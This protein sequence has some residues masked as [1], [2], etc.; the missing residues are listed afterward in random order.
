MH[1]R[2][3]TVNTHIS[4]RRRTGAL[5]T[6]WA[7]AAGALLLPAAPAAADEGAAPA[8]REYRVLQDIHTDAVST[9]LD[10]G[11]FT[12]ASK[13]DVP[14]GNGTRFSPDDIWFHVDQ[15]SAT[16]IPA[17]F[18]FIA[19][20][21]SSIWIA[22][23]SNPGTGQLWPGFSTESIPS[24]GV[25]GNQ[26]RFT[27]TG[28]EG[29][30][31]LEL[32]TT[33]GFG[34]T[35]RLWSSDEEFKSF[36]V[37]RT[38]MHANWAFT[39]PGTYRITVEGAVTI[40][41]T[42]ASDTAT[43]TFVVGDLP[44]TRA[45]TTTVSASSTDLVLGEPVTIT[46]AVQPRDAEGY[47]EFR[48]GETLLGHEPVVDGGASLTVPAPVV[49]THQ[50]TAS[51]VPAVSNLATG[52]TS[53]A[54]SVVVTEEPGGTE[55]GIAGVGGSYAP[56]D[57]LSARV[58]GAT[59][60]EDQNFQWRIRPIGTTGGGS[61]VG[62]TGTEA[63]LGRLQLP[64]DASHD[65][66]ELSVRLRT[67]TT[68]VQQTPWVPLQVVNS[69]E[70]VTA[71]LV[72]E[73]PVYLPDAIVVHVGGRAL[74][75]G[76]SLRL[77]DRTSGLWYPVDEE[78]I[79]AVGTSFEVRYPYGMKGEWAV[80][81]IRDGLAVAQSTP[82]AI[83]V[84]NAEV[85]I[86][87]AQGVYRVGATMRA[88][89]SVF[90]EREGL[91]YQWVYFNDS[92]DPFTYEIL[93]EG[94][95]PDVFSVE[96]PLTLEHDG[97]ILGFDVWNGPGGS[98]VGSAQVPINVSD[99]DP[100]EQLFFFQQLGAHYHQGYDINLDLAADPGL[101]EGDTVSWEWRW[102]G[103][104]WAAL[105]GAE[106]LSHDLVAEQAL[107]GVE[108]RATLHFAGG[109]TLTAEPVTIYVDDHGA[110]AHQ[111]ASITGLAEQYTAG[112]EVVLTASVN[113]ASVI[114]RWNWFVQRDGESSP[115]L[116]EDQ[117][118]AELRFAALE[119]LDGA[120]V[121]AQLVL[122]DGSVYVESAPVQ[123][124]IEPAPPVET[125]VTVTGLEESYE[126]G[127]T[128]T[129][130]AEQNPD[131]GEDH[132][133]WFLRHGDGEWTVIPEQ[134]TATLT[135]QLTA[136]DD[137][138]EVI[139]RLYGED[140]SV[141]GESDPVTLVVE[142]GDV[143]GEPDPDAKP[144]DA[145][146]ARTGAE[147][148]GVEEGGIELSDT[149]VKQGQVLQVGLGEDEAGTWVAA[150][151]FSEPTLLGND[152]TRADSAG[153]ISVRIPTDA[154]VGDHRLAVFA[155]DGALLG[156]AALEV[157]PADS[158]VPTGSLAQTGGALHPLWLGVPLLLLGGGALLLLRRRAHAV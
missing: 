7:V 36:T 23:M 15:D 53:T 56:G 123:L 158:T 99:A 125:T 127:D 74:T 90:P 119:D 46:G 88:T 76:E 24:G 87:V 40:G 106:G 8:P 25:D 75:E 124:N 57:V 67:G 100:D 4:R 140:H 114:E 60:G 33:G 89:A 112:D 130:T 64:L 69:V 59:L 117:H 48:D 12:M 77:V 103:Q 113:P 134:A 44:Q 143:P 92:T 93:K 19:P 104:Q 1:D 94:S 107:D 16:T 157:T 110:P 153:S 30:G 21:E 29:P 66:Y 133:H 148:D 84:K 70:P 118:G 28:F 82:V 141:I 86:E 63:S 101:A 34:Q 102:P 129:L 37:G 45:T 35:N 146:E 55:F 91:H 151:L 126:V 79:T 138:A 9:F 154:T 54:A 14:E 52:S 39:A 20:A 78:Y 22:P 145:P 156:W 68:T 83:E 49:G 26:T 155:A 3:D 38:H 85:M 120:S 81:V 98:W 72:T 2:E 42:P 132:W 95:T 109:E 121:F 144:A 18:E 27:L 139:A 62:G 51:F 5:L 147:L 116:V 131:T 11:V 128:L 73:N 152:W 105:P 150:W 31:S 97:G 149:S 6:A 61:S 137:G 41:G 115:M 142:E 65:G 80:Q 135:R 71:T 17:G 108:V 50:Y 32:F 96:L 122:P 47:L 13:A 10:A 136:E 43:Y 111:Q 58:V